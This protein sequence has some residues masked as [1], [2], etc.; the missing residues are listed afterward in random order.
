MFVTTSPV[1]VGCLESWVELG[2]PGPFLPR[3]F[4][5]WGMAQPWGSPFHNIRARCRVWGVVV[6]RSSSVAPGMPLSLGSP[7]SV[8]AVAVAPVVGVSPCPSG[9]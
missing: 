2:S 1:P 7:V 6:R 8:P 4:G 5:V 3:T 9:D